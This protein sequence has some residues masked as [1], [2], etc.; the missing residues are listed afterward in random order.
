MGRRSG[1]KVLSRRG[2]D[3]P[4]S[5]LA[6]AANGSAALVGLRKDGGSPR[7]DMDVRALETDARLFLFGYFTSPWSSW[8]LEGAAD[9][10]G[11]ACWPATSS[12][13][14]LR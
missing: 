2:E 1:G 9:P 14:R 3:A 12:S 4:E 8:D 5:A 10:C 6:R 11:L 7:G 13:L